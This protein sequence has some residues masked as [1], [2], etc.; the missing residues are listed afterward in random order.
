MPHRGVRRDLIGLVLLTT[1][2]FLP[3]LGARDLWNPSEPAYGRAVAEMAE[4]GEWL[5]PT[6]NGER[7]LEKPPLYFWMVRLAGLAGGVNEFTLR[8]PAF[9]SAIVATL[10]VYL[11]G[12]REAGV[13]AARR[14]TSR[15]PPA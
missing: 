12:R 14:W 7:F 2:L 8:L 5:V 13:F 9:L 1:L 10:F 6:V 4:A 11:L 15:R 3:G